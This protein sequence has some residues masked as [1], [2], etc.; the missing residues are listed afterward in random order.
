M[1]GQLIHLA[2]CPVLTIGPDV[3][4]PE[5]TGTFRRIVYATDFSPEAARAAIFALS[6]AQDSG[7]HIYLCHVLPESDHH[8]QVND[9]DLTAKYTVALQHL[10]PDIAC[11]WCEPECVLEHGHAVDGILLLAHRVNADLIVLGTRRFSHWFDFLKPGIAYDVI[12]SA[13]CPVLTIRG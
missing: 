2:E 13:T 1:A 4:P 8:Q 10:V 11:E 12:R 6:F 7:A 5:P 9:Q 3:R